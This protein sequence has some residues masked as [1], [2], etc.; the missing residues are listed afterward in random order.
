VLDLGADGLALP[1]DTA[2]VTVELG[3]PVPL[4]AG[5]T[6]AIREGGTTVGAGTVTAVL[7]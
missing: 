4:D 2:E 7:D 5:Q 1:G 6:F 3:K